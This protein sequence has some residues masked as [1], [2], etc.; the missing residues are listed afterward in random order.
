MDQ[1]SGQV[2]LT[3]TNTDPKLVLRS[4]WRARP[5]RGPV[6]HWITIENR[7]GRRVT[8]SQQ[9]S[10]SLMGLKPAGKA[11]LWWVACGGEYANPPG[12]FSEPVVAGLHRVLTGNPTDVSDHNPVPWMAVQVG[13]QR[14]LYVG[15][16]FSGVGGI[17]AKTGTSA[18]QLE[19]RVG[20]VPDFKTDVEPG[21][22]FLVPPALVGC[23]AG[24]LDAGSY[25]LHRFI[26]E[27][28]AA[29]HAQG[30][31]RSNPGFQ[32]IHVFGPAGGHGGLERGCRQ[33]VSEVRIRVLHY[34]CRLVP[35]RRGR[36]LAMG[37]ATFS[38]RRQVD[39]AVSPQSGH[40][41]GALVRVDGG[42]TVCG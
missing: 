30:L 22:V 18:D 11:A 33:V 38:R 29:P 36:R 42:R 4:I 39:R 41:M 7:S 2:I 37:S 28:T 26:I 17:R 6:E 23:Y 21:E 5:G 14:G 15:W 20:N 25:S 32:W 40:E 35:R 19:L 31:S 27:K 24:D 8:V 13:S 9:D 3:F 16:E 1:G 12:T 10:L 34:R